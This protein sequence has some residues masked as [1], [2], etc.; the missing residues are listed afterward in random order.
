MK[1]F[2]YTLPTSLFRLALDLALTGQVEADR[3]SPSDLMLEPNEAEKLWNME[4]SSFS[5][6]TVSLEVGVCVWFAASGGGDG[7]GGGGMCCPSVLSE[8][9]LGFCGWTSHRSPRVDWFAPRGCG[10]KWGGGRNSV[11][12]GLVVWMHSV[13][14]QCVCCDVRQQLFYVVKSFYYRQFRQ[15]K[16]RRKENLRNLRE[17]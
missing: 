9:S 16:R 10:W 15:R 13:S 6:P 7:G 11:T 1:G 5:S 4:V 8:D 2:L 17:D 3:K 12:K 14:L